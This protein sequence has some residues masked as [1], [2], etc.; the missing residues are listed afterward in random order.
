MPWEKHNLVQWRTDYKHY[1]A[2]EGNDDTTCAFDDS[3]ALTVVAVQDPLVRVCVT[4][5]PA[6]S[7][8]CFMDMLLRVRDPTGTFPPPK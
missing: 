2:H 4:T 1:P 6:G 8:L 3:H 5:L 7:G